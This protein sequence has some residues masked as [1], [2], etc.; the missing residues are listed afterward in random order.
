[1]AETVFPAH[2]LMAE[3]VQ[4]PLVVDRTGHIELSDRPGLGVTLDP[5][6]VAK[7]RVQT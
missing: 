4:E 1:M 7:Y 6:V 5:K 3:L 2:P